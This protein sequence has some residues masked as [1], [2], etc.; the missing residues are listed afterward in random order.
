MNGV[1]TDG[2]ES[3]P[4]LRTFRW[5]ILGVA[6]I[7][8]HMVGPL[9]TGRHALRAIASRTVARAEEY[10]ATHGIP[11]AYGSYETLLADPDI[12]AV[13]IPVPNSRHAE[14]CIA[15]ARAGKHVLCEKPLALTGDEVRAIMHAAETH[16]VVVTEAFMYRH[17]PV[18][19]RMRQLIDDGVI[20]RVLG[21]YGIFSFLHDRPDDVRFDPALGGGSLWDVGCYPVGFARTLLGERPVT[22]FGTAAW[23]TRGVDLSFMGQLTFPSGVVAHIVSSFETGFRTHIEVTGT[24]GRLRLTHAFKPREREIVEV[25]RGEVVEEVVVEGP[26]LYQGQV[27][28]LADAALTGRAPVVTLADSLDN[29]ETLAALLTSAQTGQVVT[30]PARAAASD[31]RPGSR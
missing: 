30:L 5:G 29:V 11:K 12:D 21:V 27:D 9:A 4:Y 18:V 15:A 25:V 10:A 17:H 16:G 26:P 6:R 19:A 22:A 8:R 3:R 28:D 2:S 1:R 20:G 23:S 31:P 24:W 7:N 13:Y 14:L